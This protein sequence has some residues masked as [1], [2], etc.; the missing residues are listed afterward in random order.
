MKISITFILIA[1]MLLQIGSIYAQTA[2]QYEKSER[3][4]ELE[5]ELRQR[6]EEKPAVPDIEKEKEAAAEEEKGDK[7]FIREIKVIGVTVF[8]EAEIR[9]I[10]ASFENRELTFREIYKVA[11][12]ITDLYRSNGYVTSRAYIPPQPISGGVL[13]I[14]VL[15]GRMGNLEIK[16]NKYF[17]DRLLQNKIGIK[18]DDYFDFDLLRKGLIKINEHPDRAARAVLVPGKVPGQTDVILEVEDNLPIHVGFEYDN[19][20]SRYIGRDRGTLSLDHNNITG[21][22]DRL[23][24]KLQRA[25]AD[26]YRLSSVN[27]FIPFGQGWETGIYAARTRLKLG[28]EYKDTDVRGKSTLLSFFINKYIK[29]EENLDILLTG[30]FDYKHIRNYL[31]GIENS[32]DEMRVA[33]LGLDIDRSDNRGRTIF[34]NEF[35]YGIPNIFGGLGAVDVNASKSGSG[36]KFTK[37]DMSLLRLQKMPF[38]STLLWKNQIQISP[39]ILTS[40]EQFQIGGISNNRGYP[41]AE[42][43]GDKGYASSLELSMPFYPIS[44]GLKVPFC[45]EKLYDTLRFVSFYDWGH[46]FLRNPQVGE[47]KY[48]TLR[49]AGCGLRFNLPARGLFARLEIGW[50]L[51]QTPSDNNHARSWVRVSKVF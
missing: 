46:V 47:N 3:D 35:S 17:S 9:S 2:G 22:D 41:P 29:D 25:D 43:V 49:S 31:L 36:G 21:H 24:L 10:T 18:K 37:W 19:F 23:S 28:E 6:I 26:A 32:K 44:K 50:P 48:T 33:K 45:E 38:D 16:N 34:V 14:R 15:E 30:G 51:D 13:E 8:S 27:Y 39:Y 11:N 5:K 20:G 7:I 12:L 42:K 1:V 40:A 4:L